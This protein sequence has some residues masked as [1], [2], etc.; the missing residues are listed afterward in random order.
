MLSKKKRVTKE[1]FSSIMKKGKILSGSFFVLR[2]MDQKD[3]QYAVVAP[4]SVS[5]G[6]VLRNKL[7]RRGYSA[8]KSFSIK[9][10]AGIFFYK[11][12]TSK[13]SF[14]E[15]KDDIGGLLKKVG[16]L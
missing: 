8:I 3:P 9:S 1:L 12:N 5:K 10:G 15:I 14:Q 6:A 2:Y 16:V 13:A 4:K 7:R 11:K